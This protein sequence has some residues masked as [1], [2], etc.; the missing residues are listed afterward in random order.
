[1][2]ISFDIL[3]FLFTFVKAQNFI[4]YII[5]I[6]YYSGSL[7]LSYNSYRTVPKPY[8][9]Q[10]KLF[11]KNSLGTFDVPRYRTNIKNLEFFLKTKIFLKK[12]HKILFFAIFYVFFK[13]TLFFKNNSK[14]FIVVRWFDSTPRTLV[15]L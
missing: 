11:I 14:F 7:K 9:T 13:K 3:I 1:M 15:L 8:R 5:L 12:Y 2:I 4:F 6:I 10:F